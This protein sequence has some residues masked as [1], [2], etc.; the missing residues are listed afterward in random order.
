METPVEE[1]ENNGTKL[2][3][4]GFVSGVRASLHFRISTEDLVI[5]ILCNDPYVVSKDEWI[6]FRDHVDGTDPSSKCLEFCSSTDSVVSIGC[7]RARDEKRYIVFR[8]EKNGNCGKK[9]SEEID[10][11]GFIM[12]YL[13]HENFGDVFVK[14]LNLIIA[15]EKMNAGWDQL[16]KKIV[17]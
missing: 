13:M 2:E 15:D 16:E 7:Y 9:C 14:M 6:A 12:V 17:G 10:G 3:Y 8:M 5:Q 1:F 4:H 11:T